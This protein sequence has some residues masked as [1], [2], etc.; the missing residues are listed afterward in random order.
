M[1]KIQWND[2]LSVGVELIDDQHKEL[3]RIAN[4][5]MNAIR[6][7][8][9]KR[10]VTNVIRRLREYTIFHFHSEEALM[11]KA[12][13]PNRGEHEAEHGKLKRDVKQFQR[14]LYKKKDLNPEH[15]LEFLKTWLLKHILSADREFARYL[16]EQ[17][18]K[19]T[20][21]VLGGN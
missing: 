9:D 12:H 1:S 18:K 15:V 16:K 14:E 21:A 19:K 13:Y 17:P 6:I 20:V 11:E 4:G 3:I 5:L 10:V 8:R 7:G 2:E